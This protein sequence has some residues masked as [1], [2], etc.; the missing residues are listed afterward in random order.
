MK[1]TLVFGTRD[2]STAPSL[3]LVG[4]IHWGLILRYV[5]TPVTII[6][7]TTFVAAR[8]HVSTKGSKNL[9]SSGVNFLLLGI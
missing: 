9:L 4:R 2:S 7:N 6:F 3:C 5:L 8:R 1:N